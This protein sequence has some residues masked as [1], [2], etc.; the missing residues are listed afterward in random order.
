MNT[1]EEEDWPN[2]LEK[3]LTS[4]SQLALRLPLGLTEVDVQLGMMLSVRAC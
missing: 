3:Q 1:Q 2:C 4:D